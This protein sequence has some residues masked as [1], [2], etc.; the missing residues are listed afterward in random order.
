[1]LLI[2]C[3]LIWASQIVLV[4]IVLEQMGPVFATFFPLTI[5]GLLLI[6]IV[7]YKQRSIAHDGSGRGVC[8]ARHL[9]TGGSADFYHLG[10][11]TVFG[12]ECGVANV[13]A[14][15][16]DRYDGVILLGERM[17]LVRWASFVLA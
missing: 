11:P 16:L 2:F 9:W 10:G 1:M 6:P 4:K 3:I 8:F 15:G 17:S 7:H 5:A 12:F 13:G 14:A